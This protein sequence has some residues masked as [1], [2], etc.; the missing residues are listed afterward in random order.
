VTS[1]CPTGKGAYATAALAQ[2]TADRM[3]TRAGVGRR[4]Y[5]CARCPGWHLT[6]QGMNSLDPI[7]PTW[8]PKLAEAVRR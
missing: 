5:K 6:S 8:L 3:R 4:I 1:S 2:R 7:G